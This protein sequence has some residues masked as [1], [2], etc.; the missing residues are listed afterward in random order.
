MPFYKGTFQE[1]EAYDDEVVAGENYGP[2]TTNWATPVEIDG[3]WYIM[4]AEPPM[5][6]TTYTSSTMVEVPNLPQPPLDQP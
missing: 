6:T 3:D 5:A 1:C 4:K 2:S